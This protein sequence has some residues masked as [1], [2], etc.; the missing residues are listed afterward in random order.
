MTYVQK[1]LRVFSKVEISVEF[2]NPFLTKIDLGIFPQFALEVGFPL[3]CHITILRHVV[4]RLIS[5]LES[6][7]L[8]SCKTTLIHTNKA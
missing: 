1:G 5:A 2:R 8:E 3:N 4:F 6:F 7:V